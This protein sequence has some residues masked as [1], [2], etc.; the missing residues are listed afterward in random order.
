MAGGRNPQ[1]CLDN[2]LSIGT[3][4]YR[5]GAWVNS[6]VSFSQVRGIA[7]KFP[8]RVLQV[9]QVSGMTISEDPG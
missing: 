8:K 3:Q 7:I 6:S 4:E 1:A 5:T 9:R 2:Y